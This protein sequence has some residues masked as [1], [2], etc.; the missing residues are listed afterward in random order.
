MPLHRDSWT[1]RFLIRSPAPA[2]GV[3]SLQRSD[4]PE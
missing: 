1:V 4:H 3:G 2:T